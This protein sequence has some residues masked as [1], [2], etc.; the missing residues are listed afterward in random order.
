MGWIDS[1]VSAAYNRNQKKKKDK[2]DQAIEKT[3]EFGAN[4]TTDAV[5]FGASIFIRPFLA[6]LLKFAFGINTVGTDIAIVVVL[7]GAAIFLCLYL[8]ILLP[9]TLVNAGINT[10]NGL[11]DAGILQSRIVPCTN[12]AVRLDAAASGCPQARSTSSTAP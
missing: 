12:A 9:T 3:A 7:W 5:T 10:F 6:P 11:N 4:R 2:V 1:A 8:T